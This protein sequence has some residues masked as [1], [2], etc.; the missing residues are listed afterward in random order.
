MFS[1]FYFK[2]W[3]ELA[4]A[5]QQVS[6]AFKKYNAKDALT[7]DFVLSTISSAITIMTQHSKVSKAS[8]LE[9]FK[10][11]LIT[12]TNGVNPYTL[13]KVVLRRNEMVRAVTFRCLQQT[14]QLLRLEYE[15]VNT[16]VKDTK[17]QIGK[18]ILS[19][20]QLGLIVAAKLSTFNVAAKQTKL[21]ND[22][23]TDASI[24]LAQKQLLTKVSS[25]D[26]SIL[27][28]HVLNEIA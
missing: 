22:I 4:T 17:E 8:Q 18:I 21:W 7:T 10:A 15:E 16:L 20:V 13:D 5:L 28:D 24:F 9:S 19:A 11:E 26:I 23:S 6:I 12:A 1:K 3:N 14:E 2:Q 27:L 25:V